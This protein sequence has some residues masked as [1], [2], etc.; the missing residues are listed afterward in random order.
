MKISPEDFNRYAADPSED[1]WLRKKYSIPNNRYYAVSVFPE[2]GNIRIVG[3][4]VLRANKIS[5]S[6]ERNSNN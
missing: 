6:N 2:P 4:R 5:K 3:D 1:S